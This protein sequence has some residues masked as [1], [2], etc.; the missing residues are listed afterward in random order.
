MTLLA[1]DHIIF[2]QYISESLKKQGS[3]RDV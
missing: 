1:G 3:A 2:M